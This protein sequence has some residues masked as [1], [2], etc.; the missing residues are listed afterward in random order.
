MIISGLLL[1]LGISW[2]LLV[3]GSGVLALIP[4]VLL[5]LPQ[6]QGREYPEHP[7]PIHWK[8]VSSHALSIMRRKRFWLF[9]AAMFVAGGGEFSLTFWSASYIQLTFTTAA[10]TGGVGTGV[11]AT[12]MIIGRM[13]G[14]YIIH[15]KHLRSLIMYAAVIGVGTTVLF[16]TITNLWVFFGILLLSGIASA[17]FWPSIQTYAVDRMPQEDST[18]MYILLSCAGIPGCGFFTWFLG[19]ISTINGSITKSFYLIPACFLL[20]FIFIGADYLLNERQH[21]KQG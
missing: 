12:G 10:W 20:I 1:T 6:Q 18:M 11:F 8:T 19:Y 14:G 3:M 13:F 17:P 15:Q 7:D 16:P 5:L 9:F 21:K 4:T 2:R